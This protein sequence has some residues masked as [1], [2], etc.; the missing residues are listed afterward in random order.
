MRVSL[1]TTLA[2]ALIAAPLAAIP[3]TA[4]A[5]STVYG[6]G[7][8]QACF[9]AALHGRTD[10]GALRECDTAIMGSELDTRDR[11]ATMVNRGVIR[12]Q[13]REPQSA[14]NDFDIAIAWRPNLGEAHVNRGAALILSG[15]FSGAITSINRGLELGT[16]DPQEAYF[17]RAVAY[18]KLDNLVAALADYRKAQELKPD[19]ALPRAELARFTVTSAR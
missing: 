7:P 13:R 10:T 5:A 8:A 2:L 14:L 1:P 6:A 11:A 4:H 3:I 18:E 12:L 15:D 17:N 9:E 16:E 19:W